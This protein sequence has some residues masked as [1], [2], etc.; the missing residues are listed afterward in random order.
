MVRAL[1]APVRP[2][3]PAR[4]R[5]AWPPR[6]PAA[7]WQWC[8][9]YHRGPHTPDGVTFRS[10]G[11][12]H[13]FDHHH[14]AASP[15][16]DESGREILYVGEDLVTSACE[17]FG[18]AGVAAICPNYRVSIVAPTRTVSMFDLTAPGAAMTIGALPSLAA[19]NETRTLTQQWAR[20]IYEDKPAGRSIY[21]VRYLSAYNSGYALALWDCADRVQI[22]SDPAE[23]L[24]DLPL[25]DPRILNR[26]QVQ[27]RQRRIAVTTVAESDC[28]VCQ[29]N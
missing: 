8:R 21:G 19:G 22:V 25:A 11:P 12:L 13:R 24:Q 1:S 28:A 14:A 27:L 3:P 10:F 6:P 2:L 7:A 29:H 18:E 4:F 17:A 23:E 20:A 26:L 5:W 16:A 15:R 9:V